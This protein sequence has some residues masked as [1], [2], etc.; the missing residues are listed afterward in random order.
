[1]VMITIAGIRNERW[2]RELGRGQAV[3]PLYAR[4]FITRGVQHHPRGHEALRYLLTCPP[5]IDPAVNPWGECD[6]LKVVLDRNTFY[7][8]GLEKVPSRFTR[9]PALMQGFAA[10]A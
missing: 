8:V 3:S 6:L 7:L 1:M 10:A 4:L 2:R 9:H 5:Q